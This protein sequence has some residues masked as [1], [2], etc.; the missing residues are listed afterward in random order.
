MHV[1]CKLEARGDRL[2]FSK[3]KAFLLEGIIL[4]ALGL[5]PT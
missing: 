2:Y 3:T 1:G 5:D 4:I